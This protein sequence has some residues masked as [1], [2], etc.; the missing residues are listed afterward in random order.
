MIQLYYKLSVKDDWRNNTAITSKLLSS[1]RHFNRLREIGGIGMSIFEVIKISASILIAI[2]CGSGLIWTVA[3]N[4]AERTADVL[5]AKIQSENQAKIDKQLEEWKSHLDVQN[6]IYRQRFD[7]EFSI[8]QDL[9]NSFFVMISAAHW[10]FPSGIDRAPATGKW[11]EICEERYREAQEKYNIA[12]S[13]LGSKA[14]FI[15][16]EIYDGLHEIV[17]LVAW[18]I[19]DYAWCAPWNQ[20]GKDAGCRKIEQDGFKRTHEIDEK[21]T[22]MLNTL[23]DY[24]ESL[25]K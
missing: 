7:V 13:L 8:Y 10:L 25:K 15:D 12:V 23:R 24:F 22:A 20:E 21:W 1:Y 11:K 14:P 16:K 18:Q 4:L 2:A 17:K 6:H 5:Q 19:N 9:C 3:K